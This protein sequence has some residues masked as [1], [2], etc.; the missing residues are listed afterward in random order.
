MSKASKDYSKTVIYRIP[1]GNL[2]YY[3]HTTQPLHKRKWG[4]KTNFK[5]HPNRKI[6]KAMRDA[7]MTE[8]DI[9]LVWVEDYSCENVNQ[10]KARERYWVERDGELNTF[11]P[12]RTYS[13]YRAYFR[14]KYANDKEFNNKIKEQ[15]NSF[16]RDKYAKNK[17]WRDKIN[18]QQS[19]YRNEK[20]ANDIEWRNNENKKNCERMRKKYSTDEGWRNKVKEKQRNY[21]CVRVKCDVCGKDLSRN[22]MTYHKKNVCKNNPI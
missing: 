12:S 18:K 7:C 20:R 5:K 16:K 6:Y 21:G 15:T 2:N 14:E 17:E 22:S 4:H 3:G 10:A 8:N 11:V 19:D 1:V 13:E 9:E